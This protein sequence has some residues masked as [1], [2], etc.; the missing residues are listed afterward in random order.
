MNRDFA[1]ILSAL[2]DAGADFVIV[3]AHALAAHGLPRA[4]GDL[5]I[6]VRPSPENARR[7]LAALRAFGAPL[8]D[9][10]EKDLVH[11]GTVFQIGVVPCRVDIL[12][13]ISGVDFDEAWS[14]RQWFVVDEQRLPFLSREDLARN[15]R[16]A[17]RPKDLVDLAALEGNEP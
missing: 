16:A 5:D 1:E 13:E 12:T 15:K 7:V 17:G 11:L 2:S 8:H 10:E 3:G 6:W 14:R 9:L 4:T